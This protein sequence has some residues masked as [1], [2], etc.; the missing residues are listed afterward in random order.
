MRYVNTAGGTPRLQLAVGG[1]TYAI[2]ASG[3]GS[4]TLT[5]NHAVASGNG[6]SD[7]ACSSTGAL[8]ANGG[9]IRDISNNI[10]TLTL[11]T[12]GNA[13]SLSFNKNIVI[14]GVAPSVTN[15]TSSAA[16]SSYRFGL[17]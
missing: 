8:S 2:Y 5:F 1:T 6:S 15:V 7:L 17:R 9:T 13:G 3:S 14:D 4:E 16:D 10:A 11:A 12:P